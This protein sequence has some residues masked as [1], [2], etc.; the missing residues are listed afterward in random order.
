MYLLFT[1]TSKALQT[2]NFLSDSTLS[3]DIQIS[4]I[5]RCCDCSSSALSAVVGGYRRVGLHSYGCGRGGRAAVIQSP[6][7]S[8]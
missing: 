6:S 2:E 8:R 7:T 3:N 4:N 5:A 1:D